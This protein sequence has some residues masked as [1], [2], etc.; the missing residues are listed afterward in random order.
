[1][2]DGSPANVRRSIE[3]SPRRL[4]TDHVDLYYQHRMDP[5]TPV[6]ETV[7]AMGEW[8]ARARSATWG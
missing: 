5:G 1:V 4:G 8:S 6:E 7:G 2:L 3:G